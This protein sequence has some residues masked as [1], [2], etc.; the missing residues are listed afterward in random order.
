M[1]AI[2]TSALFSYHQ[3]F[4][5]P[6]IYFTNQIN[7]NFAGRTIHAPDQYSAVALEGLHLFALDTHNDSDKTD[8]EELQA[9]LYSADYGELALT[10]DID[11]EVT[12]PVTLSPL[13]K[14]YHL[15]TSVP[16]NKG[17]HDH[18]RIDITNDYTQDVQRIEI[19]T[20]NGV[21]PVNGDITITFTQYGITE[22]AMLSANTTSIHDVADALSNILTGFSN[23]GEFSIEAH[24][25][26]DGD[27]VLLFGKLYVTFMA[28]TGS[29]PLLGVDPGVGIDAEGMIIYNN[30]TVTGNLEPEIQ[31]ITM[32]SSVAL[33]SGSFIVG[34]IS[35]NIYTKSGKERYTLYESAP[36]QY[37][38]TAN[39]VLEALKYTPGIGLLEVSKTSSGSDSVWSITFLTYNKVLPTVIVKT[40]N[41]VV[42]DM[43]NDTLGF[44]YPSKMY[45]SDSLC[46]AFSTDPSWSIERV[47]E[48]TAPLNGN[49]RVY[50]SEPNRVALA[51]DESTVAMSL[52]SGP[53]GFKRA[54]GDMNGIAN[55]NILS[56][57]RTAYSFRMLFSV[58]F[59]ESVV[60]R[61]HLRID[62][63]NLIGVRGNSRV[64]ISRDGIGKAHVVSSYQFTLGSAT[65]GGDNNMYYTSASIPF[66]APE[67]HVHTVVTTMLAAYPIPLSATIHQEQ[68]TEKG[69]GGDMVVYDTKIL[70]SCTNKDGIYDGAWNSLGGLFTTA[71]Q[72]NITLMSD[73]DV[74]TLKARGG[75]MDLLETFSFS[76]LSTQAYNLDSHRRYV[77]SIAHPDFVN[78][79]G[80]VV[81]SLNGS[82][83][84]TTYLYNQRGLQG[85]TTD[86]VVFSLANLVSSLQAHLRSLTHSD[87]SDSAESLFPKATV[88]EIQYAHSNQFKTLLLIDLYTESDVR[89]TAQKDTPSCS[90]DV[91]CDWTVNV[92]P[93][94]NLLYMSGTVE[95]ISTA[96]EEAIY[97]PRLDLHFNPYDSR[98]LTNGVVVDHVV[99]LMHPLVTYPQRKEVVYMEMATTVAPGKYP[100]YHP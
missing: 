83:A 66:D 87:G 79:D 95:H 26:E 53:S 100:H 85:Y 20:V 13:S 14:G 68:R 73:W 63:T 24:T 75:N 57:S 23:V 84:L 55:A 33:S 70:L 34:V 32:T 16:T 99:A 46:T 35:E 6:S 72:K 10:A 67:E 65:S 47:Q 77:L 86:E 74:P 19:L 12:H 39:D 76:P 43:R 56:V 60:A 8:S 89:F 18:Y 80:G 37:D 93:L 97:L 9:L 59:D 71:Q 64:V 30:R 5:H 17:T 2:L 7:N 50:I 40:T 15:K 11:A 91:S 82:V 88:T 92:S 49:I 29:V 36:L 31:S 58:S 52:D 90:N 98:Y 22:T 44:N 48:L 25:R 28:N 42:G 4:P 27:S 54:I 38:C 81:D 61:S 3:R 51:D 94:S 41:S 1:S 78:T 96:I 62:A 45:C 69:K 21:S